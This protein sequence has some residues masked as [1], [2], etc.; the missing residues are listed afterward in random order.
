MY[1]EFYDMSSGGSEK[2][3]ASIIFIEA[4]LNEA[5]ELFEAIF[6]LDPYN[7]TCTCCGSDYSVSETDREPENGDWVVSKSDILRFKGG[8]KLELD[9]RSNID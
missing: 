6:G 2:L 8:V 4:E 7:V 1:T 9:V 5:L 3:D